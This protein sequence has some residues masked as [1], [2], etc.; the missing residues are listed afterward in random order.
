MKR[1][2]TLIELLVVVAIIAILAAML[3]PA[4]SKAREKART[5]SCVNNFKQLGLCVNFYSS[6][7]EDYLPLYF[8]EVGYTYQNAIIHYI[9]SNAKWYWGW[10]ADTSDA[11]KKIFQCPSGTEKIQFGQ[12]I[13]YNS[14]CGWSSP[15]FG[16]PPSYGP[17]RII[18]TRPSERCLMSETLKGSVGF[19]G[20]GSGGDWSRHGNRTNMLFVDGHVEALSRMELSDFSRTP[21][22]IKFMYDKR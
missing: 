15:S 13:G 1:C 22:A 6:D 8:W 7:N 3:L 2:F 4:L 10:S 17:A 21:E 20:I 16:S 9:Q 18:I 12:N 5:V 11:V 14:R 19:D